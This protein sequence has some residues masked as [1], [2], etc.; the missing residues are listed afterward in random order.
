MFIYWSIES[1]LDLYNT[2][3]WIG[4]FPIS[5]PISSPTPHSLD[6]EPNEVIWKK[7]KFPFL[8]GSSKRQLLTSN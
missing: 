1:P 3:E 4:H 5:F 2:L 6:P 7:G 8:S